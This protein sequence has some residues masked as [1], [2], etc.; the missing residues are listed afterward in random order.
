MYIHTYIHMYI[1]I[2]IYVY[3]CIYIY[4]YI[5]RE[6][7]QGPVHPQLCGR[8]VQCRGPGHVRRAKG[9]REPTEPAGD[10]KEATETRRGPEEVS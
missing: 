6:R 4:I 3:K 2:Y 9:V 7:D 10:P 8:P 5:E 1:Y